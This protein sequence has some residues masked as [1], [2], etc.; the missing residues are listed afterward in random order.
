MM[1][2]WLVGGLTSGGA[3]VLYDGSPFQPK[4]TVLFDLIDDVG[5]VLHF[6]HVINFQIVI[7]RAVLRRSV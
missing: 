1:W 6:F 7:I 5:F 4:I 2:N 3:I